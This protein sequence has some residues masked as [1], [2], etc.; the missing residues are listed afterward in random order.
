MKKVICALLMLSMLVGCTTVN[1]NSGESSSEISSQDSSSKEIIVEETSSEEETKE[2]ILNPFTGEI[3]Q[4]PILNRPVAVMINNVEAALPQRGIST[5]DII[6]EMPV[7]YE[8]TRL[9]AVYADYEKLPDIGSV[10]SARH[11]FVEL[12][13][14]F[15]P[16]YIHFG[17]S[18]Y[19]RKAI[20]EY[21]INNVNGIKIANTAFYQDKS[22]N[23]PSEHTWFTDLEHFKKGIQ[24][25]GYTT[26]LSEPIAPIF[27]FGGNDMATG[28]EMTTIEVGVTDVYKSKFVYDSSINKYYQ[29]QNGKPRMDTNTNTQCAVTNVLVM[30]TKVGN[31][32]NSVNKEIT[33]ENGSGF[34][35]CNGKKIDV[36][37]KKENKDSN[38][39]VYT[40]DGKE[41]VMN[42]GNVWV[43]V[44][45]KG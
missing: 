15:N 38:L 13:K 24:S 16:L 6:Y 18:P 37:F 11:D 44:T 10:R 45:N 9:M 21:G 2:L 34:Y 42:R 30:N 7:E 14:P 43:C 12:I 31:V 20:E 1:K 3:L 36:D 19:G 26:T 25:N 17:Y 4:Q 32:P 23:K 33:L 28:E 41:L 29:F 35:L 5:A 39:K 40:K 27:N 8:I 22:L